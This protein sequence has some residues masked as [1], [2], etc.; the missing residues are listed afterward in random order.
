M[1][2]V[3]LGRHAPITYI[4]NTNFKTEMFQ[5][6]LSI[7]GAFGNTEIR[8]ESLC[9]I[10]SKNSARTDALALQTGNDNGFYIVTFLNNAG[11]VRGIINGVNDQS[12]VYLTNSDR[13]L[14]K[15][16]QP[17]DSMLENIMQMKPCSFGWI[18]NEDT[19]YGFIA[20]E[21]HEI[22][23][24]LRHK[25]PSCEESCDVNPCDCSGNPVYY[26]L[27]YG[28]FTPYI[29]KAMQEMK[30]GYDKQLQEMKLNYEKR[31]SIIEGFLNIT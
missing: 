19:G 5:N 11:N 10:S 29:V 24:Q 12:I 28:Q 21:V 6:R 1:S 4:G 18:S 17:M 2:N 3:S 31:L 14:K 27:D 20:Q 9:A 13:R 15:N 26:G 30:T 23:P 22:F 16:I 25:H 8:T 7:S